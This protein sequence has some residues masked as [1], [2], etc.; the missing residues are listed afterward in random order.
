MILQSPRKVL[1]LQPINH[2]A[3]TAFGGQKHRQRLLAAFVVLAA[4]VLSACGADVNSRLELEA[5]YSGERRFVL[6]MLDSDAEALNGGVEAASAALETHTP[7]VLEFDGVSAESE[8]QSASFRM[9]FDNLE[10]YEAN[11]N[12]LL[13]LSDL[14]DNEREMT[15]E[16][17]DQALLTTLVVEESFYNDDLMRWAAN[18]LI[19]EGVV[20][21]S[22][23]VFTSN[24]SASVI[25]DGEEVET[26][27]S[28][29]R[30]NFHLTT[31]QRFDEV[32][33]DFEILDSDD[34]RVEMTYLFDE[35]H[36]ETQQ[37]FL[38]EQVAQ[39]ESLDGIVG[40]VADSGLV[41]SDDRNAQNR[42]VAAT[43]STSE[44]VAS[45]IQVLLANEDATFDI[46]EQRSQGSPDSSVQYVGTNW[47]CE[48]ICDPNNL[49]QLSGETTYPEHWELTEERRE[50]GELFLEFNRGMPL[51]SFTSDT[52]LQLTGSMVQ[53]FEFV[54]DNKNLEGHE[55]MVAERFAPPEATGTFN[56]AVRD[57]NTLYTVTFEAA[58]ASE[59]TRLL[60]HY[61]ET[62][63]VTTPIGINHGP[64]TGLWASYDV[65]VDLSGIW[66]LAAGGVAGDAVTRIT[67]P[68]MHSGTT[69]NG[70]TSDRTV[71]AEG[72]TGIFTVEA[73]GPTTTTIWLVGLGLLVLATLVLVFLRT[74]RASSRVWAV[75]PHNS[76]RER[77]YNVQGP[78]DDLTATDILAS[79]K[80]PAPHSTMTSKMPERPPE[81]PTQRYATPY[82]FPD[83]ATPSATDHDTLREA[84]ERPEGN[85]AEQHTDDSNPDNHE[86]SDAKRRTTE[87]P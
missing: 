11:I 46:I 31:D 71:V 52:E 37:E 76:T 47:T 85:P 33:L 54:V 59:M 82:R 57:T 53:S 78:K 40:D 28:L 7:D 32:E 49:Q 13:E 29:P 67:L 77:P 10:E 2:P 65:E 39:L 36:R 27:T 61:L 72:S 3:T 73:Q 51:D 87:D 74:R 75:A 50:Q 58:D 55:D 18:A 56:T 25:F 35:D 43:F 12:T 42:Q 38:S 62:K 83:I 86:T 48:T 16:F 6:T 66:E 68:I 80:A 17:E 9:P 26:S 81:R 79:P 84:L 70:D 1:V 4:V 5:D 23:T 22:D 14:P 63:D 69:A 20:S 30:M 24:G 64:I 8:G 15:I 44:A 60:N 41:E 45:G 34:V 21:D 19:A